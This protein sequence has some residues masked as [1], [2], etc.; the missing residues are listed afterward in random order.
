M[1]LFYTVDRQNYLKEDLVIQLRR[2]ENITPPELQAHVD[3]LFPDGVSSHGER[4][5]LR[6][7]SSALIAD[8]NI[9]ILFE[10]VR[11]AS[12]P[13]RPSRFQSVFAFISVDEAK[14]F[15][16]RYGESNSLIW[17]LEASESFTA[18]MSLLTAGNSILVYSYFANKY[19]QGEPSATPFWEALLFPPVRVL[20][21]V[22]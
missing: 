13:A 3:E 10:Y 5:F 20:R 8:P 22:K 6:G 9:E 16:D 7:D 1:P 4:Y 19:W 11:R 15:R 14:A 17:E 18:D 2:Y 12:Y 21:K